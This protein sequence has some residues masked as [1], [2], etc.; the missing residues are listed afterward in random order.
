MILKKFCNKDLNITENNIRILLYNIYENRVT[1]LNKAQTNYFES[2]NQ[3]IIEK[4]VDLNLK[5]KDTN[6]IKEENLN[7]FKNTL[8]K[9]INNNND[10]IL[11][12]KEINVIKLLSKIEEDEIKLLKEQTSKLNQENE[13]KTI[14]KSKIMDNIN[15]NNNLILNKEETDDDLISRLLF[16][17]KEDETKLLKE[18]M[19]K[20]LNQE[21]EDKIIKEKKM[22]EERIRL[23][24]QNQK[25][26]KIMEEE[27]EEKIKRITE[28]K[29]KKEKKVAEIISNTIK[30]DYVLDETYN[31]YGENIRNISNILKFIKEKK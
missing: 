27:R 22:I 29:I 28:E 3:N 5:V 11:S 17:V 19:E 21:N 10:L 24:I 6:K 9:N 1:E 20:K 15:N 12:G 14:E 25:E 30:N 7:V 31:I 23:D 8:Q 26:L 4:I 13:N 2:F 16:E 18:Q